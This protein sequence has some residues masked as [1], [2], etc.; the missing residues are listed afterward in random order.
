MGTYGIYWIKY[1]GRCNSKLSKT[2]AQFSNQTLWTQ[3]LCGDPSYNDLGSV[4][5]LTLG[6]PLIDYIYITIYSLNITNTGQFGLRD[7]NMV[8]SNNTNVPYN[9][10]CG[11]TNPPNLLVPRALNC[12]CRK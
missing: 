3:N 10:V 8:F 5:Y 7:V 4:K 6:N 2:I 11:I 1:Y 12:P 9:Q